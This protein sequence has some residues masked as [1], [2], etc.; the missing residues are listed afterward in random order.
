MLKY[1]LENIDIHFGENKFTSLFDEEKNCT[2][3]NQNI[4]LG[5]HMPEIFVDLETHL[6]SRPLA[7]TSQINRLRKKLH[8]FA[9]LVLKWIL[10]MTRKPN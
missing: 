8:K 3:L 6:Q 5:P 1:D 9:G 10:L 7:I 4:L 2:R